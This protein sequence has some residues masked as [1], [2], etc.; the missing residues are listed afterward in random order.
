[1]SAIELLLWVIGGG[2]FVCFIA[3]VYIMTRPARPS[4]P[5]SH[6]APLRQSSAPPASL[7]AT[8]ATAEPSLLSRALSG[9][10][11]SHVN[12][13]THKLQVQRIGDTMEYVVDGVTYQQIADIPDPKM[14]EDAER[15]AAKLPSLTPSDKEALARAMTQNG[16]LQA[17]GD[18]II[19]QT[20]NGKTKFVINGAA[21][22]TLDE[23]PDAE[24]RERVRVLTQQ[25]SR[26]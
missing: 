16:S 12:I 24:L 1:M 15:I 25:L 6:D 2:A 13:T 21:Y 14:R 10:L 19:I 8:D 23:I 9:S 5:V 22:K 7:M 4:R 26:G 11:A 17:S 18:K 20:V 3:A